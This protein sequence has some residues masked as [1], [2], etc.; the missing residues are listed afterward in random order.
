MSLNISTSEVNKINKNAGIAPVK[1]SKNTFDVV[2]ASL[3]YSEKVK[4]PLT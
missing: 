3:I 1:V 2:K 4:V